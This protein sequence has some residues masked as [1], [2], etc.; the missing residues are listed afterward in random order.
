MMP[1]PEGQDRWAAGSMA[2]AQ[3]VI[4]A[5]LFA[6]G[7]LIYGLRIY[8]RV[9]IMNNTLRLDDCELH[10]TL[11]HSSLTLAQTSLA[12][13]CSHAG[14]STPAPWVVS[15]GSYRVG[16]QVL[17]THSGRPRWLR[18]QLLASLASQVS[19]LAQGA[20][21]LIPTH[22]RQPLTNLSGPSPSTSST[23][24]RPTWPR[25]HCSSSTSASALNEPFAESS[26]SWSLSSSPTPSSTP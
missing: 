14:C 25:S 17:T 12:Q 4:G 15:I 22:H 6:F 10:L 9:G 19:G 21:S 18:Y 24:Y 11:W 7:S 5:V 20:F 16:D 8:T 1:V 23:C 2:A 13:H 3:V 26:R